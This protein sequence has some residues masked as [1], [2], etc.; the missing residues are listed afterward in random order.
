MEWRCETS[1]CRKC[2]NM[3]AGSR[4]EDSVKVIQIRNNNQ[5]DSA[6]NGDK[7]SHSKA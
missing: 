7:K 6:N 3:N 5:R 1:F 2:M 4:Q